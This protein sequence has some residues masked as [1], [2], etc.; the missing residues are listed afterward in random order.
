MENQNKTAKIRD[1]LSTQYSFYK[2]IQLKY[3]LPTRYFSLLAL[4]L[5]VLNHRGLPLGNLTG[6]ATKWVGDRGIDVPSTVRPLY[7]LGTGL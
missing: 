2:L 5:G 1:H 7:R 3:I 6:G 4:V